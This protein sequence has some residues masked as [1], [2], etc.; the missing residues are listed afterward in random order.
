M[1]N[2]NIVRVPHDWDEQRPSLIRLL[3]CTVSLSCRIYS[4]LRASDTTTLGYTCMLHRCSRNRDGF[5][6][7]IT[8]RA[9]SAA[10]VFE[11]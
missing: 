8:L 10:H 11:T 2:L 6:A 9:L 5:V 4:S 3:N 7:V 1:T